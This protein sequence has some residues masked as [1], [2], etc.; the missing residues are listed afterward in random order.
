ML[1]L[2]SSGFMAHLFFWWRKIDIVSA[3]LH[4]VEICVE[5][6][7]FASCFLGF[8]SDLAVILGGSEMFG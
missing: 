3:V 1:K 6:F 2:A 5:C 4:C 7:G 8:I